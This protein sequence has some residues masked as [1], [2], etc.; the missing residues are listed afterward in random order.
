MKRVS[1]TITIILVS[2]A[3]FFAITVEPETTTITEVKIMGLCGKDNIPK[4]NDKTWVNVSFINGKFYV[5]K[6]TNYGLVLYTS[7][8][9]INWDKTKATTT[10]IK[11]MDTKQNESF[12]D[13][14]LVLIEGEITDYKNKEIRATKALDKITAICSLV[15]LVGEK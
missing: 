12:C 3:V 1:I 14:L 6:E 10:E 2:L 4:N 8:D 15:S 7:N 11:K 5:Y 9:G 13:T